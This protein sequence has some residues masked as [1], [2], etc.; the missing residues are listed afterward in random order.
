MVV[1]CLRFLFEGV[2]LGFD[3]RHPLIMLAFTPFQRCLGFIDCLL[4]S[5]ALLLGGGLF[6][7]ALPFTPSLFLLEGKRG[8][9]GCLV[10]GRSRDQLLR[11][12]NCLLW[13]ALGLVAGQ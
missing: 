11:F 12:R 7:P 10:I 5:L 6:L 8:L 13:T 3:C 4:A 1:L 2:A 9:A